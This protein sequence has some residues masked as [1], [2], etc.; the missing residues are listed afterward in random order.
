MIARALSML[1]TR[2]G[3]VAYFGN[4]VTAQKD[5][6]RTFLHP[7]IESECGIRLPS[8]NAGFGGVGSLASVC[9]MDRLVLRHAPRLCFIECYTGDVGDR[10]HAL[11]GVAIEAMLI[12]LREI[13]AHPVILLLPR[14][15]VESD[16]ARALAPLH[17]SVAAHHGAPVIDL[18]HR[19][20][21]WAPFLRDGVHTT[22]EGAK[23]YAD[24]ILSQ[25]LETEATPAIGTRM[26][27]DDLSRAGE[28]SPGLFM[29]RKR[30]D[31]LLR[32]QAPYWKLAA[33]EAMTVALEEASLLGMT[34]IQGP[35][36]GS[37][38]VNGAPIA[39]RDK[40]STYERLH[41]VMLA[42]PLTAET[43]LEIEAVEGE[44]RLCSFLVCPSGALRSNEIFRGSESRRC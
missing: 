40:W 39:L 43:S 29:D 24:A 35:H 11:S 16:A 17:R 6:F 21:E 5:G 2:P 18:I 9:M 14:K 10:H 34:F 22:P 4:S 15:D 41:A 23:L 13:E 7:L 20:Q 37:I 25:L 38:A 44:F 31:G 27:A 12:K 33:G 32:L 30:P 28:I 3:P 36:A 1:S 19:A 8:V 26:F 42:A